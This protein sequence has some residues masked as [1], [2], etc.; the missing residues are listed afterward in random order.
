MARVNE[1]RRDREVLVA[2]ALS[3]PQGGRVVGHG[4]RGCSFASY[5]AQRCP[6]CHPDAARLVVIL[7]FRA[8]Q[9]GP[10]EPCKMG[11]KS[12]VTSPGVG[13]GGMMMERL[14]KAGVKGG[15]AGGGAR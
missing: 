6:D 11:F 7:E 14:D 10:P 1:P 9:T 15:W 2:M 12:A 3:G 13:L 4:G 8:G 5:K